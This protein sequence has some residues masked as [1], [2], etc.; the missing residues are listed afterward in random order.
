[1]YLQLYEL[2]LKQLLGLDY[3][4]WQ[5]RT[6]LVVGEKLDTQMKLIGHLAQELENYLRI[7]LKTIDQGSSTAP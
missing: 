3:R 4:R 7:T 5:I 1:M 6:E 2:A